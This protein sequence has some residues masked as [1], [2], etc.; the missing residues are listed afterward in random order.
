MKQQTY[1]TYSMT[2]YNNNELQLKTVLTGFLLIYMHW[3]KCDCS[4]M[5]ENN[6]V[7][8]CTWLWVGVGVAPPQSQAQ[9]R[10]VC[11]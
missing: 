4:W 9:A 11:Y 5:V 3:W 10:V 1:N 8:A 6:A 7:L 2:Q